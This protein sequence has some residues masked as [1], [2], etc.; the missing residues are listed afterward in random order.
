MTYAP[1]LPKNQV[2]I[3]LDISGIFVFHGNLLQ[4]LPST[5]SRVRSIVNVSLN[6]IQ[7]TLFSALL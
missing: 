7:A 1:Q 6:K 3:I 4:L 5:I 2:L